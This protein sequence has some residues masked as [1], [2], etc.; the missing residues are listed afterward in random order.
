MSGQ[1]CK[2][3]CGQGYYPQ[4][5]PQVYYCHFNSCP[6]PSPHLIKSTGHTRYEGTSST[7]HQSI[8]ITHAFTTARVTSIIYNYLSLPSFLQQ[9]HLHIHIT[10][11]IQTPLTIVQNLFSPTSA[12]MTLPC[13]IHYWTVPVPVLVGGGLVEKGV[14]PNAAG[15]YR[16]LVSASTSTLSVFNEVIHFS[17]Q[18][19]KS[20][21]IRE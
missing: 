7:G 16:E 13:I 18:S 2:W 9:P 20:E 10:F 14:P 5:G 1:L 3:R 17:Q 15:K 6:S 12:F 19:R 21:R 4:Q 11:Q 8:V